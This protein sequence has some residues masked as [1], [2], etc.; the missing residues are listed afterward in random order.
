[1]LVESCWSSETSKIYQNCALQLQ[2]NQGPTSSSEIRSCMYIHLDPFS[3]ASGYANRFFTTKWLHSL[4]LK[5]TGGLYYI[6]AYHVDYLFIIYI[7]ICI[8]IYIY[9]YIHIHIYIYTLF[10]TPLG[11][12]SPSP[13]PRRVSVFGSCWKHWMHLCLSCFWLRVGV[14]IKEPADQRFF[15][16]GGCFLVPTCTNHPFFGMPIVFAYTNTV[17]I[18]SILVHCVAWAKANFKRPRPHRALS[19]ANTAPI[20]AA[21]RTSPEVQHPDHLLLKWVGGYQKR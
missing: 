17:D 18:L 7:Y 2:L 16:F 4:H 3:R 6:F 12:T 19:R 15:F 8:H 20:D 21:W 11:W 13:A 14:K 9:I 1:M 5:F 10:I